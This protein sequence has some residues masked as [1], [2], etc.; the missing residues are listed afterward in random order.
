MLEQY[1]ISFDSNRIDTIPGVRLHYYD[2]TRLPDRDIKIYKLARRSL[3]IVTSS[4]YVQKPI[5][6]NLHINSGCRQDTEATVSYVKSLIS[7]QNGT[8]RVLQGG[9]EVEYTV[10]MSEFNID[11]LGANAF[12]TVIF[13]ASTPTGTGVVPNVLFNM[14]GITTSTRSVTFPVSGSFPAESVTTITISSVTGGTGERIN[15]FNSMNNQ[16]ISIDADYNSGDV[17]IIDS[18]NM[19]V[20]L[21]GVYIDFQGTFPTFPPG[22]QQ[23]TYS[24][25]FSTR[26]VDVSGVANTRLI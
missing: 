11:W 23:V 22:S 24:D 26:L 4:E 16:G 19:T 17:L 3:S 25:T 18:Y 1:Q 12:T 21:N 8:L 2:F 5:S 13:I 14:S 7:R 6:I 15:I 20:N 9:E 10:T